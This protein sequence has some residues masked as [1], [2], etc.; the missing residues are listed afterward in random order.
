MTIN[1]RELWIQ[2]ALAGTARYVVPDEVEDAD[3]LVDDMTDVATKYADEMLDQ[4]EQRDQDG[5]FDEEAR[6]PRT[7]K[8]KTTKPT[9]D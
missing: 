2:F 3:E 8:R 7:R 4:F 6:R 9:E 5:S 1:K